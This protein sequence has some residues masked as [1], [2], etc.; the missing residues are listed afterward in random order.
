VGG[1]FDLL[2]GRVKRAPQWVQ[3]AGLEWLYRAL[4]EPKRIPRLMAL[5]R[6]VWMTLKDALRRKGE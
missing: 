5:P 6:L 1:T 2:A 4:R 3:Q